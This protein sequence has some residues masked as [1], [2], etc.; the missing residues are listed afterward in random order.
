[1]SQEDAAEFGGA[2]HPGYNLQD[3][4]LRPTPLT[5]LAYML[6]YLRTQNLSEASNY[7]TRLDLLQ[8]GFDLGLSQ[9]AIWV[10]YYLDDNDNPIWDNA[11]TNRIRFFDNSNRARS[12]TALF[13]VDAEG[14]YRVAAIEPAPAYE[15]HDL[16]TPA[17]AAAHRGGR[18]IQASVNEPTGET[19]NEVAEGT[20]TPTPTLT[21]TPTFTPSPTL[22]P[23]E[24]PTPAPT[25]TPTPTFTITPTPE[26]TQPP[27]ETSTPAPTDT[28]TP[29]PT[30]TPD[31]YPIPAIPT[32]QAPLARAI[33][34]RSPSNLRAGPSVEYP[35]LAALNYGV[36]VDLFGITEA[37]DWILLR[38]NAPDDAQNGIIGWIS[39]D[40][41]QVTGDLAFLPRY[42]ADGTPVVPP[43]ATLTTPTTRHAD[44]DLDAHDHPHARG[45][46]AVAA[47]TGG[48]R[49]AAT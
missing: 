3:A 42:Y 14:D 21:T 13:E 35:S 11:T 37:G 4:Q 7:T 27:T 40:L 6:Q 38:I 43:T 41:L 49:R 47:T 26:P 8:Q 19:E 5:T 36:P 30:D 9:P 29:L 44:R 2:V 10:A 48:D 31:P 33:V 15:P 16:L 23:T 46:C 34:F 22:P 32:D 45:A 12:F 20:A 18:A 1:M 28:E 17:P 25:L 24:T 39:T